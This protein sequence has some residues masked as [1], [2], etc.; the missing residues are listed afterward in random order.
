MDWYVVCE[1][2]QSFSLPIYSNQ[3][4]NL[5]VTDTSDQFNW[6]TRHM[7]TFICPSGNKLVQY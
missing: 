3:E 7:A 2:K 1:S 5:V 4:P 6:E